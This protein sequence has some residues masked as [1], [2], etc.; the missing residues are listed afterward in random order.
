M[1]Y[2]IFCDSN[3]DI[4]ENVIIDIII[5]DNL[6]I[7]IDIKILKK[8]GDIS[9]IDKDDNK[10]NVHIDDSEENEDKNKK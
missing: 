4:I 9:I 6:L 2:L 3:I 7:D 8:C 10:E 5:F 1:F